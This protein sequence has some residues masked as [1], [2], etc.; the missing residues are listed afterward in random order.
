M[1]FFADIMN[2]TPVTPSLRWASLPSYKQ[3]LQFTS[4]VFG[5]NTNSAEMHQQKRNWKILKFSAS[6]KNKVVAF[7]LFFWKPLSVCRIVN[8]D[9]S[10][11]FSRVTSMMHLLNNILILHDSFMLRQH[12]IQVLKTFTVK[13]T[14]FPIKIRQRK[15]LS[16]TKKF[17]C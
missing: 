2:K 6:W 15:I 8:I 4:L 1:R 11:V 7:Q 9:V 3:Q 17:R 16:Y 12:F 5:F 10:L 14:V 13:A